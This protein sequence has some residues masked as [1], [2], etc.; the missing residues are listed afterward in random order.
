MFDNGELSV[1]W[2]LANLVA[3]KELVNDGYLYTK[4]TVYAKD[5]YAMQAYFSWPSSEVAAS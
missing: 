1:E 4:R 2:E 3:T 5:S